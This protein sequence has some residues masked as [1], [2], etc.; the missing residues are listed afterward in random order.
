MSRPTRLSSALTF[1][2]PALA[3]LGIVAV[4]V[5]LADGGTGGDP[6]RPAPVL[7]QPAALLAAPLPQ[8]TPELAGE[9]FDIV[10]ASGGAATFP[11]PAPG[12]QL[13]PASG[14]EPDASQAVAGSQPASAGAPAPTSP[15]PEPAPPPPGEAPAE[16]APTGIVEPVVGAVDGLLGGLVDG[17]LTGGGSESTEQAPTLTGIL[18]LNLGG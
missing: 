15:P 13:A 12:P 3:A 1:A 4:G 8:P 11:A 9:L 10:A 18:G 5:E 2:A 16:P 6:R 17:L 7:T 14:P